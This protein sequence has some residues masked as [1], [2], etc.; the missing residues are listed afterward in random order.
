MT[1]IN[2]WIGSE[3]IAN[4][5]NVRVNKGEIKTMEINNKDGLSFCKF[6][7]DAS[8]EIQHGKKIFNNTFLISLKFH[9]FIIIFK[10][11]V[12]SLYHVITIFVDTD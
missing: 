12:K 11:K 5:E 6:T 8:F 9:N 7:L 2:L 1:N 4:F 10:A 3:G